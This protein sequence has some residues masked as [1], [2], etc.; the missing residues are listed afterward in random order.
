MIR[1]AFFRWRDS[2]VW[3]DT[4]LACGPVDFP[5][6]CR[7]GPG[8]GASEFARSYSRGQRPRDRPVVAEH[9]TGDPPLAS[10]RRAS[11]PR[12]TVSFGRAG[13]IHRAGTVVNREIFPNSTDWALGDWRLAAAGDG[14]RATGDRKRRVSF[15]AEAP[16]GAAGEESLSSRPR[17]QLSTGR[18]A[19][20]RLRAFGAALGMTT[21]RWANSSGLQQAAVARSR[22]LPAQ[23]PH[24]A[25]SGRKLAAAVHTSLSTVLSSMEIFC[26]IFLD[27]PAVNDS[28]SFTAASVT[29]SSNRS[30]NS[31]AIL[32]VT[33][34]ISLQ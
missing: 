10:H 12:L 30:T 11:R 27:N 8:S 25:S 1:G 19:I 14:R 9:P 22:R 31:A 13:N 26:Q 34:S 21:A 4:A 16:P 17:G 29:G 6:P 20:P 24:V 28:I 3:F 5:Y 7:N 32:L 33:E 2:I 23:Q 15:R 18:I